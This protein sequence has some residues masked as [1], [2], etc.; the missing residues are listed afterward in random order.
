MNDLKNNRQKGF[1]ITP[2]LLGLILIIVVGAAI[3]LIKNSQNNSLEPP[4]VLKNVNNTISQ[5]NSSQALNGKLAYIHNGDIWVSNPDGSE[6]KQ[7]TQYGYN[8]APIWSPDAK[9]IAY[10]SSPQS[11]A[12][13]GKAVAQCTN[14]FNIWV[15]N[16]D[17]T[18]PIKVTDSESYRSNPSW[19][20]DGSKLVFI[21]DENV[22]VYDLVNKSRKIL[23]NDAYYDKDPN[24][25]R[26]GGRYNP[27]VT[28]SP[29]SNM[30]LYDSADKV[31]ILDAENGNVVS[32]LDH[33][34]TWSPDGSKIAYTEAVSTNPLKQALFVVSIP[35]GEKQTYK[36]FNDS[37]PSG[38]LYWSPNGQ[39]VLYGGF[40]DSAVGS[41]PL[42]MGTIRI[43][44]LDSKAD[45]NVS[46]K[47]LRRFIEQIKDS[48]MQVI[49][50]ASEGW[51]SDGKFV[52]VDVSTVEH[53][54]DY[55]GVNQINIVDAQTGDVVK[56]F[57]EARRTYKDVNDS[58]GY[59][60]I[61]WTPLSRH[62]ND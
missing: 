39:E 10:T 37:A 38:T 33:F 41:P 56:T 27:Q 20:P 18:N 46:D 35:N 3:Y 60:S 53:K 6:E 23:A 52:L 8:Y 44:N 59:Y 31:V 49:N 22:V 61:K 29:K 28:W 11:L 48:G 16:A 51:S 42:K 50:S 58:T 1:V 30:V 19:S 40:E 13:K 14:Y 12:N 7:L 24:G 54:P 36:L 47:A 21:E 57:K 26:V 34:G 55:A 32:K 4:Q 62:Q 15:I 17:G 43:L 9:K 5:N 45:R 25:C 2:L